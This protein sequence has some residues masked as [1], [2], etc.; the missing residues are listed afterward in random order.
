MPYKLI[1]CAKALHQGS[2]KSTDKLYGRN[3][4]AIYSDSFRGR[5]RSAITQMLK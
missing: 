1:N 5:S 2:A 3:A 4:Q